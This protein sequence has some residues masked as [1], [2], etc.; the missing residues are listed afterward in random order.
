MLKDQYPWDEMLKPNAGCKNNSCEPDFDIDA[1]LEQA[2]SDNLDTELIEDLTLQIL[3]AI[4]CKHCGEKTDKRALKAAQSALASYLTAV[5][6]D[7]E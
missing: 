1:A 5:Q 3:G 7:R 6:L 2:M 4:G